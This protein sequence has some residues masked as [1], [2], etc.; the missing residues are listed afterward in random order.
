MVF[1]KMQEGEHAHL[2]IDGVRVTNFKF[3]RAHHQRPYLDSA[4]CQR[5]YFIRRL[6]KLCHQLQGPAESK[7]S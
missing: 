4:L 3:L 1:R 2:Y 6:K 5:L 7:Y